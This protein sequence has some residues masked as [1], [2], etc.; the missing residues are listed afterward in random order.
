MVRAEQWSIKGELRTSNAQ[1]IVINYTKI[2]CFREVEMNFS[3]S[4]KYFLSSVRK[5]QIEKSQFCQHVHWRTSQESDCWVSSGVHNLCLIPD[6]QVK[7][8][9]MGTQFPENCT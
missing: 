2:D 6:H 1:E 3:S 8:R 4:I 9:F 7:F 5:L